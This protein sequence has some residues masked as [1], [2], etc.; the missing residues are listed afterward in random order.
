[1]ELSLECQTRPANSKANALRHSGMIPAVLYGHNGV[2][3]VALA[4]KAKDAELLV[5]DASVNNTLITLNVPA[6]PWTGKALLREVQSHPWKKTLYHLS[7]FSVGSHA[8]LDVDV[9]VHT[10]G[11]APG[12]KTGGGSLDLQ[13]NELQVRCAPDRIPEVIEV[14]VSNLQVGDALHVHELTLPEGVTALVEPDQIVV[15][16]LSG[17]GGSAASEAESGS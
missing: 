9:P 8:T 2:E 1:M 3:S 14:D 17:G 12:V 7:F 5:R 4:V 15:T 13:I 10:V 6:L 11:E 16:V